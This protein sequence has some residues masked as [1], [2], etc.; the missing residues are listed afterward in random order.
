MEYELSTPS[1]SDTEGG[2]EYPLIRDNRAPSDDDIVAVAETRE[3][4]RGKTGPGM[5]QI[6]DAKEHERNRKMSVRSRAKESYNSSRKAPRVVNIARKKR[7][8]V[9]FFCI[10]HSVRY[11]IL[12]G[13]LT[14][15]CID[16]RYYSGLISELPR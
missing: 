8:A 1:Q 11:A 16:C 10:Y 6:E 4:A 12:R 14:R 2:P 3:P 9:R 7:P 15:Y 13:T 5:R